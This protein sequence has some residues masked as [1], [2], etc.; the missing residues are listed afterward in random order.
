MRNTILR[1]AAILR[2]IESLESRSLLSAVAALET[3]PPAVGTAVIRGNVF[4]DANRNGV[5]DSSEVGQ[6]N[7]RVYLDY[8][9][10]GVR[11]GDAEPISITNS[12]GGFRFEAARAPATVVVRLLLDGT[13]LDQTRPANHAGRTVT[14]TVG[15]NF[16]VESFGVAE[17]VPTPTATVLSGIVY[18][19]LNND[20]SRSSTEPGRANV[21]V[22]IDTNNDAVHQE[23]E[24]LAKTN[25]E[26]RYVF[27]RVSAGEK[28]LRLLL[29]G[30]NLQQT[31]PSGNAP[32]TA[33][34]VANQVTQA[35]L[36]GVVEVRPTPTTA[37]VSGNVFYDSNDNSQRDVG[38]MGRGNVRV[39]LD[40]DHDA[41]R[42]EGEPTAVTNALGQYR[43]ERA[44]VSAELQ[45]RLEL[46]GTKLRQTFPT[47][48]AP[49][50]IATTAGQTYVDQNFG[51][52][53]ITI[54]PPPPTTGTLR[55]RV[56][57]DA[58]HDGTPDPGEGGV[59]RRVVYLDLD[60]SGAVSEGEPRLLTN[61]EGRY[62][63]EHVPAGTYDVRLNRDGI[64][65]TSPADNGGY[66]VTLVAGATVGDLNFGVYRNE[67]TIL[68]GSLGGSLGGAEVLTKL[69]GRAGGSVLTDVLA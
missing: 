69:S 34:V 39:Y 59:P 44:P 38:E 32:V 47:G 4:R 58:D 65:Q 63:F 57:F 18:T 46:A 50:V 8:N 60:H 29:T 36:F 40:L 43:F 23:G 25:A 53:E 68:A 21:L 5:R 12:L 2:P 15:G 51:V 56:F 61:L 49:R 26:G 10:N 62:T 54:V 52:R 37:I 1:P 22:Y 14:T 11:D 64:I 19:D 20:G 66:A 7:V 55:G 13:N 27:E 3:P 24:P 30:T 16:E 48:N 28:K 33:T 35:G 45:I 6:P 17:R 9:N 67:A 42:E 31:Q 41:T